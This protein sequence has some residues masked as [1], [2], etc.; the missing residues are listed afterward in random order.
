MASF[1]EQV[2][3]LRSRCTLHVNQL[4]PFIAFCQ[5]LD[6]VK[7]PTKGDF[8]VLRMRH[9]KAKEPLL[10]HKKLGR[11]DPKENS[12][13]LVHYTTWGQSAVLVKQFLRAKKFQT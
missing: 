11:W 10:V 4:E 2:A 12:F 6:W 7:L 8:E 5:S 9:P 13:K 1:A 3:R